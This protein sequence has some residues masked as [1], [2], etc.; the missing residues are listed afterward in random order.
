MKQE[1]EIE[2]RGAELADR[3]RI[4]RWL[5]HS[6]ATAEMMGPPRFSDHPVPTYAEFCE[7]YG[8]SFFACNDDE[9]LFVISVQGR[10]IG[11]VSLSVCDGAAELD[12]WIASRRHWGRRFG[13]AAIEAVTAL[14][15]RQRR[16]AAIVMR[17]SS[18]NARAIASYGRSGFEPYDSLRHKVP[19]WCLESGFD[20]DDA[21]VLVRMTD[22][23]REPNGH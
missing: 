1:P 18:R 21:V 14:L 15:E 12:I 20:Y 16:V 4:Y 11:A 22:A 3:E 6:D 19:A 2:L 23:V 10:D 5:A 13:P 9:R 7:D 8:D 17:P